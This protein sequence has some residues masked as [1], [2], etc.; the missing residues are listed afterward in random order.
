MFGFGGNDV[1]IGGFH[2]DGLTGGTGADTLRFVDLRDTGDHILDFVYGTDLLDFAALDANQQLAGDQSFTWS[3]T[4]PTAFSLW[5]QTVDGR[6]D[7]YADTDGNPLTAEFM[8]SLYNS[9]F[10]AA[11]TST[12]TPPGFIF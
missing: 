3:G 1:L 8:I 2:I 9:D 4:A 12:E 10:A 5:M 11:H 6:V 7:I